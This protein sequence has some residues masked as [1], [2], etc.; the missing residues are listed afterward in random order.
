MKK[1]LVFSSCLALLL[2]QAHPVAHAELPPLAAVDAEGNPTT[3][4]NKVAALLPFGAHKGYGLSLINELTAAFIGG[5]LPLHRGRTSP[6]AE[7]K[8]TTS[9]FFQ[10]IHPEALSA[11][12]FASGRNQSE[13]LKAVIDNILLDNDKSILPGQ[14]EAQAAEKSKEAGGLLFSD[15]ELE[16]LHSIADSIGHAR[17]EAL[18]L[19][20]AV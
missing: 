18:N 5:S 6:S 3:D 2:S 19:T 14:L 17:L 15:A 7:E 13:N 10:I 11:G 12:A 4:P 16:E 1:R 8:N 9:F 20:S